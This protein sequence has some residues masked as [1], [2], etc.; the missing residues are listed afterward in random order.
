VGHAGPRAR[1]SWT[2]S[3]SNNAVTETPDRLALARKAADESIVLLKNQG[4]A[5]VAD[6][7]NG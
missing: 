7:V 2:N 5:G 6:E 1:A 3:N 4:A